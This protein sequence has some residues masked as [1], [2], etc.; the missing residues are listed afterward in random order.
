MPATEI[1]L[2]RESAAFAARLIDAAGRFSEPRYHFHRR[3]NWSYRYGERFYAREA[4]CFT[5]T[6]D[7]YLSGQATQAP[8]LEDVYARALR[9]R[10]VAVV[11]LK[12]LAHW[13]FQLLGHAAGHRLR[14]QG[15]QTYRKCYVDDIE[16]VFNPAQAGVVRAVY[17][18]PINLRRQLAYLAY[19][20]REHLRFK[21]AGNPYL[22]SDLLRFIARRDVRSLMRMESRAQLLHARHVAG[23][24]VRAVQL[25][26]EFDIGSL[27]FT[28]CLAR[29]PVRVVNS[30]HGVGKYF[31]V[32]AYQ[33]FH[34]LTLKQ[35][36]YYLGVRDCRY[37]LRRLNERSRAPS[38]SGDASGHV[39]EH[40]GVHLVFLS[41]TFAGLADIIANNEAVAVTRLRNEFEGVNGIRLLYKPHPNRRQPGPPAAFEL[42]AN[43]EDVNN[44][45][46]TIFVSFFST[47]QIDPAFKG[48]KLL[49][50][51]ELIYPGIAFDDDEPI[52][53]L[54]GL[55]DRVRCRLEE[56]RS[57]PGRCHPIR[58][59]HDEA[60][61]SASSP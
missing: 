24:G 1:P 17:P 55:V 33:E 39:P 5:A 2:L 40:D 48:L 53:D 25:S 37:A 46:G 47:C 43:L 31:P 13:L 57:T 54:N 27:D 22:A 28:R 49:L 4:G 61:S 8:E 11:L 7:A 38:R 41:Q 35:Q 36:H 10:Q 58:R 34:V 51:G 44:R 18:F 50:R 20:R 6:P 14:A 52:L 26:D 23:L 16:L 32:H 60:M 45:A 19:L 56:M 30:A 12:V 15:V 21:L 42:L 59:P 3:V 29:W 9:P